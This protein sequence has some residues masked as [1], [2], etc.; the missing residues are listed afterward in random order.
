MIWVQL[1]VIH[2]LKEE[3]LQHQKSHV[4]GARSQEQLS[5][6]NMPLDSLKSHLPVDLSNFM[7]TNVD[8]NLFDPHL[9][10]LKLLKATGR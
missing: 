2:F 1:S 6:T 8:I 9:V 3:C 7:S 5:Y 4:S 10:D